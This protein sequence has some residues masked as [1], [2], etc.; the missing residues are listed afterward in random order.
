MIVLSGYRLDAKIKGAR[1]LWSTGETTQ[2]ITVRKSGSYWVKVLSLENCALLTDTIWLELPYYDF[3]VTNYSKRR[4]DL[5]TGDSLVLPPFMADTN[6][7]SYNWVVSGQNNGLPEKGSGN[8]PGFKTKHIEQDDSFKITVMTERLGIPG[9]TIVLSIKVY[10]KSH[11]V[12]PP[13]VNVCELNTVTIDSIKILPSDRK[14]YWQH[15]SQSVGLISNGY[16]QIK[17]F[18]ALEQSRTI[19]D[20]FSIKVKHS[21][22]PEVSGQF[23]LTVYDKKYE[24]DLSVEYCSG[25][26]VIGKKV[27]SQ[28]VVSQDKLKWYRK[29][30][31]IPLADSGSLVF[32]NFIWP[33]FQQNEKA[34]FMLTLSNEYC[35]TDTVD[36]SMVITAR[37]EMKIHTVD[38]LV[39]CGGDKTILP[40]IEL[41]S[42]LHEK[43][44]FSNAIYAGLPLVGY[45]NFPEVVSVADTVNHYTKIKLMSRSGRCVGDSIEI[46]V[47]TKAVP[48][49][50]PMPDVWFCEE[51]RVP[52]MRFKKHGKTSVLNW[53][54]SGESVAGMPQSGSEFMP[55][56]YIPDIGQDE[57]SVIVFQTEINGCKGESRDFE[58]K[59]ISRPEASFYYVSMLN[60]Q[61]VQLINTGR[62]YQY[63]K[64]YFG[65][66]DS[67]LERNPMHTYSFNT[68]F[69]ATQILSNGFCTDTFSREVFV[70]FQSYNQIP[71]AF[72]P[73]QN[74]MNDGFKVFNASG[75]ATFSIFNAW[76]EMLYSTADNSAWDGSY[77]G[78][79]CQQGVYLYVAEI[80][81]R[82]GDIK[83]FKGTITLLK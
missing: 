42:P 70:N 59:A 33:M 17:S 15:T 27:L 80:S 24:Q 75:T 46:T 20:T 74:D 13:N 53:K 65:D 72:S 54:I 73:D 35:G 3:K 7:V 79:P 43:Y 36:L 9:D 67:S 69:L 38:T 47:L 61:D 29:S 41:E 37:P 28:L 83:H 10:A 2:Y 55:G 76:G 34:G 77:K 8:L 64:W 62:N 25:D 11:I 4:Y 1:Y 14:V 56:F 57:K 23:F 58:F 66:G 48:L 44:W 30:D 60:A 40:R 39:I 78:M 82:T 22:C 19:I 81:D 71:T 6:F 12:L 18:K 5:C 45:G 51:S 16:G 52:E 32:P 50:L 63:S 26:S 21:V 31:N 68:E 49:T